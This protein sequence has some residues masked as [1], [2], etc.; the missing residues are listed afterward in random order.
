MKILKKPESDIFPEI[1]CTIKSELISKLFWTNLLESQ[2]KYNL[3]FVVFVFVDLFILFVEE[4][5]KYL[6]KCRLN[7][8]LFD[9]EIDIFKLH[10]SW[11]FELK[12][13]CNILE[14]LDIHDGKE[15]CLKLYLSFKQLEK[16]LTIILKAHSYYWL[17]MNHIFEYIILSI[18]MWIYTDFSY[19]NIY[20]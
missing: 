15:H 2:Q 19:V 13:I 6:L 11:R 3:I 7:D 18:H 17:C 12:N 1:S 16:D 9:T 20:W 5:M 4:F 14:F 8:I 10:R